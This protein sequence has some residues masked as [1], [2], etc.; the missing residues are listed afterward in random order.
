MVTAPSVG[1][2][3]Q[4]RK[5]TVSSTTSRAAPCRRRSRA[6]GRHVGVHEQS[7]EATARAYTENEAD[8][9]HIRT[10]ELAPTLATSRSHRD[11][12]IFSHSPTRDHQR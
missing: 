1:R 7:G 12:R 3:S 4:G 9:A 11:R 6:E 10:I 5:A 2:S 8:V